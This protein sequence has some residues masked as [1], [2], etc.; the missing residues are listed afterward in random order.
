MTSSSCHSH[1]SNYYA[2]D[3]NLTDKLDRI[4]GNIRGSWRFRWTAITLASMIS[5]IGWFGSY[6]IPDTYEA[7]ARVFVDN[8]TALRPLLEGLTIDSGMQSQL[9]LVRRSMLSK[10]Q[11]EKVARETGLALRASTPEEHEYLIRKLAKD[12][13]I[14]TEFSRGSD[15]IYTMSFVDVDRDKSIEVVTKLL[16]SFMTDVLGNKLAGQESAQLFLSDQIADYESRLYAAESRLAE[17][18][19]KNL[20]L[21]PGERGDYFTRLRAEQDELDRSKAQLRLLRRRQGQLEQQLSGE[22]P[23]FAE[24]GR[25][26]QQPDSTPSRLRAAETRLQE[27]LLR[28]TEKHPEVVALRETI[29]QLRERYDQELESLQNLS[30]ASGSSIPRSENL[31][32]QRI[33]VSL[34]EVE[35]EIAALRGAISDRTRRTNDLQQLLDTA[36]EVEAEFA[37]LNRDYGVTRT[38][39][40]SLVQRLETARISE[41]ADEKG[42]VKFEVIDPP[43]ALTQP[44]GPNH[45]LLVTASL[46]F[47]LTVGIGAAYARNIGNPVFFDARTLAAQSGV[48]VIGSIGVAFPAEAN[49]FRAVDRRKI[50]LALG[51]LMTVYMA[52]IIWADVASAWLQQVT[53]AA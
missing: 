28:F 42:V 15:N 38:Q 47:G 25:D 49:R 51:A 23:F 40:N 26:N 5:L 43:N 41:M 17:F 35:V 30:D 21:V 36:P 13:K 3:R 44:I 24:P 48:P 12:I 4:I 27:L 1:F 8:S 46:F 34:N 14:E 9:D 16:E 20:G 10:P 52:A 29:D 45:A 32:Y 18:K 2:V 7:Q 22:L 37:R 53:K 50:I 39:Y 19:K 11:L 31:V 6:W 33:R